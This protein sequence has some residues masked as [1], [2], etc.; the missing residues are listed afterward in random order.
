MIRLD[1]PR[2]QG[3]VV[4]GYRL[5]FAGY[6]FLRIDDVARAAAWIAE[7]TEDVLT[8]TPWTEKPESGVNVAFSFAGLRVLALPDATLSAFPEEFRQGMAARAQLLG[9]CGDSAPANWEGAWGESSDIHVL[10]MI[11]AMHREALEAHDRRLRASLERS[12]GLTVVGDDRG[13][14]Q[15]GGV[16]HFGNVDGFA[17]PSI[18]GSGVDPLPGQGA[19][20]KGGGWRPIRAGEFILG[21]PDEENT[22]P[23][24]PPPAELTANGSYL[25]YRK[26][27]QDVAS[28]RA[29]LAAAAEHFLGGEELLAAKL[30]GRWRDGTPLDLS[31][32]QP[33]PGIVADPERNN[34]FRYREDADGLRCPLGAHV[35][36]ANPRDSLPFEGRLVNRHRLIRRGIPYGEP[37]PHGA[38]DDGQDRGFIFACLQA[39]IARQFEFVQ[40]QWLNDGNVLGLGDDRDVLLCPRED[41]LA[42]NKMT[43]PGSPPFF[44]APFSPVVTVKGGEYFFVPGINGLQFLAAAAGGGAA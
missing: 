21:Y 39:S 37:L 5:Q 8:A 13:T 25:V 32:Q 33:D 30:V 31:P 41:G 2:I 22:L 11:S 1:L 36:R 40:S 4:R 23:G 42:A 9:D 6:L 26:L 15:P 43:V 12:G 7:I 24:A 35:R 28:F 10:V 14:A 38:P 19:V 18:E 44:V 16:E 20:L 34:A 29:Q 27:H 17:Q 3:F